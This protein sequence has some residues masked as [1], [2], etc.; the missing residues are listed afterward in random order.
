MASSEA[1]E[2]EISFNSESPSE[3]KLINIGELQG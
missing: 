1:L 3:I 2:P